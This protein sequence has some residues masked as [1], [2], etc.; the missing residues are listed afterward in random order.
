MN[1]NIDPQDLIDALCEDN[2]PNTKDFLRQCLS[3]EVR[4]MQEETWMVGQNEERIK[5]LEEDRERLQQEVNS[6]YAQNRVY[7][8]KEKM[9]EHGVVRLYATKK[10]RNHKI[11]CIKY[12]RDWT[13]CGLREAKESVESMMDIE[14]HF[15]EAPKVMNIHDDV[16][17]V[18]FR[19]EVVE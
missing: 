14:G 2:G 9:R 11:P 16:L 7:I 5:C 18:Y 17:Q 4:R 3:N 19:F 1:I 8:A 10:S 12:I 15:V 6:L 13:G